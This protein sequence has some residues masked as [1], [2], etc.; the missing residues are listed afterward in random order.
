VHGSADPV[1][2]ASETTKAAGL[3]QP[4]G[5]KVETIMVPGLGHTISADGAA[6]AG[7]FIAQSLTK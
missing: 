2:P 5:M 3:L 6:R 7:T 1:I 4:L